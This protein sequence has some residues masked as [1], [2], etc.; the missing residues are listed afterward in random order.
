MTSFPF[1]IPQDISLDSHFACE[2]NVAEIGIL[3]VTIVLS[4]SVALSS[5]QLL[6]QI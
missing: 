2:L 4:T 5:A 3:V 1:V 6:M